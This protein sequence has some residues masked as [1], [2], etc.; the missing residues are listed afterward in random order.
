MSV[1][2]NRVYYYFSSFLKEAGGEAGVTAQFNAASRRVIDMVTISTEISDTKTLKKIENQ[3]NTFFNARKTVGAEKV[4]NTEI[5]DNIKNAMEKAIADYISVGLDRINWDTLAVKEAN[6]AFL[7]QLSQEAQQAL[8]VIQTANRN[9]S[10]WGRG[11]TVDKALLEKRISALL[12]IRDSINP[13]SKPDLIDK[14]NQLENIYSQIQNV[15]YKNISKTTLNQIYSSTTGNKNADFVNV[16]KDILYEFW[17]T[18]SSNIAGQVGEAATAL[19]MIPAKVLENKTQDELIKFFLEYLE[20]NVVGD[21]TGRSYI[22]GDKLIN[23]DSITVQSKGQTTDLDKYTS[24]ISANLN[25]GLVT[26]NA[27][28]NK[29]DVNISFEEM[30]IPASVKNYNLQNTSFKGGQMTLLKASSPIEYVQEEWDTAVTYFLN[31]NVTHPKGENSSES[32]I[33]QGINTLKAIIL[34]KALRGGTYRIFKDG[35]IGQDEIAELLIVNDSSV[36][37]YRVFSTQTLY[38]SLAKTLSDIK[39]KDVTMTGI[40]NMKRFT[41]QWETNPDSPPRPELESLRSSKVFNQFNAIQF[42]VKVSIARLL[43]EYQNIYGA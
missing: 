17:T 21:Q 33:N 27:T 10:D 25:G 11:E 34:S 39:N 19:A 35:T 28:Q 40:D 24:K 2:K 41:M 15:N 32:L 31:V 3:L 29:V 5:P 37:R 20:Q 14:L 8:D 18:N 13:D 1:E 4:D 43:S 38:R 26:I 42:E 30:K 6:P 23:L 36:G 16:I 9:R 12:T 7:S 22:P